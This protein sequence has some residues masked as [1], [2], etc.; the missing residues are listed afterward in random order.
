MPLMYRVKGRCSH[1]CRGRFRPYKAAARVVVV[2]ASL[3]CFGPV[4]AAIALL[5]VGVGLS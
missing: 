3:L 2:A 1:D 4:G 5:A